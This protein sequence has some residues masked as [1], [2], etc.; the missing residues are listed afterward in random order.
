MKLRQGKI[1]I[2]GSDCHN[3]STRKPN[4]MDALAVINTKLGNSAIEEICM[5]QDEIMKRR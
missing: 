4:L 5:K 2:L 1:H 3:T